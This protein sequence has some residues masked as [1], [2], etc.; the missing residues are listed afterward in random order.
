MRDP[1]T[2]AQAASELGVS[3]ATLQRDVRRGCPSI[4]RPGEVGRGNGALPDLEEYRRWRAGSTGI[5]QSAL[6]TAVVD[7]AT[8]TLR[9]HGG[10]IAKQRAHAAF[11]LTMFART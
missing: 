3:R 7:V 8:R 2:L 1:V 10:P 4:V 11:V 6:L 5:D 9:V